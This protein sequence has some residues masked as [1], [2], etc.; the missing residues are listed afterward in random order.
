MI[1]SDREI[2]AAIRQRHIVIDPQPAEEQYNTSALDL[3]LRDELLE[4]RSLEELQR[5]EPAGVE[6]TLIIDVAK[7]RMAGLLQAYSK[8]FARESDGSF[9]LPPGKFALGITHEYVELPGRSR[10]A[11]R[12][13]DRSTLARLGLAIHMTAPTIHAGFE[14]RIVLE[15]FNFGPYPLRLRP[16]VFAVCQLI[17]ERLGRMPGGQVKTS[18]RGQKSIR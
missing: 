12:V 5:A 1:L 6:R 13:E 10:I 4:L 11:A 15:I 17:F 18:Y 7:V 9:V 8:P 16:K 3:K 14:G 2:R